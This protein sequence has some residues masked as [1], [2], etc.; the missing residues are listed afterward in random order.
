MAKTRLK[1]DP[2]N[3]FLVGQHDIVERARFMRDE[4]FPLAVAAYNAAEGRVRMGQIQYREDGSVV[5][6]HLVS[7]V[8]LNVAFI[9][10][11]MDK[12]IRLMFYKTPLSYPMSSV[13]SLMTKNFRYMMN[14]LSKN[15][16]HDAKDLLANSTSKAQPQRAYSDIL[17]DMIASVINRI[18]GDGHRV[19]RPRVEFSWNDEMCHLLALHFAGEITK[20]DI[21][22]EKLNDFEGRY[23]RYV[24]KRD[25]FVET[26][27]GAVDFFTGDKWVLINDIN[28][29]VIVGAIS[30]EPILEGV[31]TMIKTGSLPHNTDQS[32]VREVV[33]FT[34]Y[35]SFEDI[36][37]DTRSDL[38]ISLLMLKSHTGSPSLIPNT[39]GESFSL[40]PEVG[41]AI[42]N[43]H[44][45]SRV[46]VLHK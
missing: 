7:P 35:P 40:Y 43:Y 20:N 1:F 28:K 6:V 45:E 32:Y 15:S 16:T 8:G 23:K 33:P 9:D 29:G 24:T 30:G 38:E 12:M 17:S 37:G 3:F 19:E 13:P 46:I 36:P 34:W 18:N 42:R 41:A 22:L 44:A 31:Q 2:D 39:D 27:R 25:K 21:S 10:K 14:K 11:Q 5:R 26:M 4:I